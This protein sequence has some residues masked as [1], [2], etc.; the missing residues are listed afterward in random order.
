MRA[1]SVLQ[2]LLDG[3]PA[4]RW[5]ALRDLQD[6]SDRTVRREQRRVAEEG[7][8]ARLLELQGAGSGESF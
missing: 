8:G 6:A 3:D 5:Q 1:A 4:V 2:W 7:W